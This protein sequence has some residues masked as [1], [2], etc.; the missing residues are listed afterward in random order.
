MEPAMSLPVLPPT[1]PDHLP[2]AGAGAPHEHLRV[3]DAERR[4]VA[5]QLAGHYAA[6]RLVEDEF[7]QRTTAAWAARTYGD[8]AGLLDDLPPPVTG[9]PARRPSGRP[10][11]GAMIGLFLHAGAYV[12]VISALWIT[13][14]LSGAGHPWPLYPMLGWGTGVLGHLAG[15]RAC[16]SGGSG[17]GH[18]SPAVLHCR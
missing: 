9:R 16:G 4:H 1:T 7:D 17:A 8:L 18:R 14:L 10:G 2:V 15:V 6:G 12:A 5:E 3:G 11:A 13:W